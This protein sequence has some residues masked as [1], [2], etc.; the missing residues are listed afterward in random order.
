MDSQSTIGQ[1]FAVE[2]ALTLE[3]RVEFQ[4]DFVKPRMALEGQTPAQAANVGVNAKNKW[5]AMLKEAVNKT[6]PTS[7]V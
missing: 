2:C 3:R 4:Y 1:T 7:N 5:L 6:P